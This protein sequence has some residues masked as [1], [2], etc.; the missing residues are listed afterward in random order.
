MNAQEVVE[1]HVDDGQVSS[2]IQRM[3]RSFE[4]LGD[5]GA[6]AAEKIKT[7]MESTAA[8]AGWSTAKVASEY[9]KA[10]AAGDKYLAM[11]RR[12]EAELIRHALATH[13]AVQAGMATETEAARTIATLRQRQINDLDQVRMAQERL[14]AS[15]AAGNTIAANDNAAAWRR[16]NLSYQLFDVSQGL[17]LGAPVGMVAMQQGPQIA[18]MYTGAGGINA[19]LKDT[20]GLLGGVARAAG[21]AALVVGAVAAAFAGVQHEINKTSDVTVTFGDVVLGTVDV[22]TTAIYTQLQ[23]AI[24]AIGPWFSEAWDAII[25]GVKWV[26]NAFVAQWAIAFDAMTTGSRM[27]PDAFIVAGELAA[28]GFLESIRRMVQLTVTQINLLM[29]S[30]TAA[31]KGTVL[32]SFGAGLPTFE[33]RGRLDDGSPG[34]FA[35]EKWQ[36]D[37]G[38][39]ARKR[40]ASELGGFLDRSQANWT[41]DW[42]AGLFELIGGAAGQRARDRLKEIED[43]TK[44]AGK[45]ALE[46]QRDFEQFLSIADRLAE[47][48]FPGEYARREAV[49]LTNL[50]TR[51]GSQL[52]AFQQA[53]VNARIGDMFKAAALGVRELDRDTGGANKRM[54]DMNGLLMGVAQAGAQAFSRGPIESWMDAV[55]RVISPIVDLPLDQIAAMIDATFAEEKPA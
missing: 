11:Q 3:A 41:Y 24:A 52:D 50:M 29:K 17:A 7:G 46:A 49:E 53:A 54:E 1:L 36:L 31:T 2:A 27:I 28:N 25:A 4:H 23:P 10:V 43:A 47:K 21:P 15:M 19:A 33:N 51:F 9:Q 40:L 8:A 55:E 30:I 6:R 42:M 20:V 35:R 12:Q 22:A 5:G 26:G 16:R 48:M 14:N 13:R 45:A 44:D 32:E 38:S 18:Q 34:P 37:F 39:E